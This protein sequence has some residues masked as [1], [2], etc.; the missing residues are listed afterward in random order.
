MTDHWDEF[1]KSLA[2]KSVP[3]RESLRRLGFV[4]AGAVLSPLG[5]E[6]AWAAG[7]DPCKAFCRCRSK[8]DQSQ[9]L[10]ACR[11]CGKDTSRLCGA[12]GGYGCC[13]EELACCDTYCADLTSDVYNCGDCGYAC[14][15]PGAYETAVCVNGRC[16]YPCSYGALDCNGACTPVLWDPRNC[17]G[18]G[19]VC[20]ESTPYCNQGTCG[21]CPSGMALCGGQCISILWDNAN[22]GACG[23]VCPSDQTCTGG[24]CQYSEPYP[25]D[26]TY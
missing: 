7:Q 24:Y 12:C 10:A 20:G 6:T 13:P 2:E 9:C 21:V 4:L 14:G 3:R 18:C 16:E 17:G 8:K 22:C 11:A 26:G 19:N 1:S 23:V 5:L 25:G 15:A